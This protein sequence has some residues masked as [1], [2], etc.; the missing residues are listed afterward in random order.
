[1]QKGH[2]SLTFTFTSV[3]TQP[4]ESGPIPLKTTQGSLQETKTGCITLRQDSYSA[5]IRVSEQ[6]GGTVE[7]KKN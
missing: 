4:R 5:K 1:M 7:M 3:L 2:L 6:S